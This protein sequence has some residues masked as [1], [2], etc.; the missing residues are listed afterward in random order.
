M[1]WSNAIVKE[2]GLFFLTELF[3]ERKGDSVVVTGFS[4]EDGPFASLEEVLSYKG[5]G[6]D[7]D[8]AIRQG[9]YAVFE[10]GKYTYIDISTGEIIDEL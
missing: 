6:K 4:V 1:N 9:F 10:D 3:Y 5:C 8:E 2:N 7:I